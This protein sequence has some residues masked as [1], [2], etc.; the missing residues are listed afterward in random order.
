MDPN[1]ALSFCFR[2][3]YHIRQI[4]WLRIITCVKRSVFQEQ[5]LDTTLFASHNFLYLV[6]FAGL[7]L[8]F[9][10]FLN[11]CI[12]RMPRELSVVE[13]P[14]AMARPKTSEALKVFFPW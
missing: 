12:Y 6:V 8:I 14:C 2:A 10:S 13:I 3:R 11:V 4:L 1:S 9:G 5:A 7:G